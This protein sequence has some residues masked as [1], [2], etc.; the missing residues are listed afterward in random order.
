MYVGATVHKN[1]ESILHWVRQAFGG[2]IYEHSKNAKAMRW[3]RSLAFKHTSFALDFLPRI[4]KHS[5]LKRHKIDKLIHIH[6][7]RLSTRRATA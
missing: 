5:R 6:S 1:D 4:A 3:R 7:Q 2:E